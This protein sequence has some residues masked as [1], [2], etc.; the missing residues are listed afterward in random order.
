MNPDDVKAQE[1]RNRQMARGGVQNMPSDLVQESQQLQTATTT[2]TNNSGSGNGNSA[3]PLPGPQSRNGTP[4]SG[5]SDRTRQ[6]MEE[7]DRLKAR[8]RQGR[9]MAKPVRLPSD[10][11]PGASG[12]Q[13]QVQKQQRPVGA[14]PQ[15]HQSQQQKQKQQTV[16]TTPVHRHM[17]TTEQ[18]MR[19]EEQIKAAARRGRSTQISQM[20]NDLTAGG[21]ANRPGAVAAEPAVLSHQDVKERERQARNALGGNSGSAVP[22]GSRT[23]TQPIG[24]MMPSDLNNGDGTTN[25]GPSGEF[26]LQQHSNVSSTPRPT[27]I[28]SHA[29]TKDQ[30]RQA[31]DLVHGT[32]TMSKPSSDVMPRDLRM[33][34]NISAPSG[35]FTMPPLSS[36]TVVSHEDVKQQERQSR[37]M[38]RVSGIDDGLRGGLTPPSRQQQHGSSA[39]VAAS[40]APPP[41][42]AAQRAVSDHEHAQNRISEEERIKQ[43]ERAARVT[44]MTSGGSHVTTSHVTATASVLPSDLV[45][46]TME[47]ESMSQN[48]SGAASVGM[49][50]PDISVLSSSNRSGAVSGSSPRTRRSARPQAD[51][52]AKLKERARRP[53]GPNGGVASVAGASISTAGTPDGSAGTPGSSMS[54][55]KGDD[56]MPDVMKSSAHPASTEG[57][58]V[59]EEE[60]AQIPV[61]AVSVFTN[62]VVVQQQR[63][64]LTQLQ[65]PP[66]AD[67]QAR[68]DGDSVDIERPEAY[69]ENN[70]DRQTA[71]SVGGATIVT[72]AA[73]EQSL[74]A[75]TPGSGGSGGEGVATASMVKIDEED[76]VPWYKSSEFRLCFCCV[77][78]AAIV[79]AVVAAVLAGKDD[80]P[81][82]QQS[83]PTPAPVTTDTESPSASPTVAPLDELRVAT[84]RSQVV[85]GGITTADV[86]DDPNTPQH[87]AYIWLVRDDEFGW[88]DFGTDTLAERYIL[89]TF[90]FSLDGNNWL[91]STGWLDPFIAHCNWEFVGCGAD[92]QRVAVINTGGRPGLGQ[93]VQNN[94]SGP[95]PFEIAYLSNLRKLQ[96]FLFS[97]HIMMNMCM[98]SLCPFTFV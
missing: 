81:T 53:R 20:P 55:K 24:R 6:R 43:R 26:K 47:P 40:L 33:G 88:T 9:A 15:Q 85:D 13:L 77:I 22:M 78:I 63:G 73:L 42:A 31:R 21:S 30:E 98:C 12:G 67:Y 18:R 60:V 96:L 84:L 74:S 79:G 80:D 44:A 49:D 61:G 91:S 89:A 4:G 3:P 90:Y 93:M 72:D 34:N 50:A 52:D 95:L 32:V 75:Y 83:G 19:E 76:D 94:L 58:V 39:T 27:V 86:L 2:T 17:T 37:H 68:D 10:L 23:T 82:V 25:N 92:D 46:G 51:A 7:E 57:P 59:I 38:G 29:A 64:E 45:A 65:A 54:S 62:G 69:T 8:A 70:V 11:V 56:S 35:E 36:A 16:A 28:A 66:I 41:P 5:M 71:N 48:T 97:T 14:V 1:R 87:K